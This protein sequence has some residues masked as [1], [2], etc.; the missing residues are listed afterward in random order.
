LQRWASRTERSSEPTR[1]SSPTLCANERARAMTSQVH[2]ARE[3]KSEKKKR[4][5]RGDLNRTWLELARTSRT[6]NQS[7]NQTTVY[8]RRVSHPPLRY[9]NS[10]FF[11]QRVSPSP[12]S[13]PRL[14]EPRRFSKRVCVRCLHKQ[15]ATALVPVASPSASFPRPCFQRAC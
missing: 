5:E 8:F 12:Q 4:K 7:I 14:Q 1:C 6:H 11:N 3:K 10:P 2:V 9:I 15:L 13:L